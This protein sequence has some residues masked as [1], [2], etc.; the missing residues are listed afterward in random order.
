MVHTSG[1]TGV[2]ASTTPTH[3]GSDLAGNFSNGVFSFGPDR[4]TPD[5]S[6][7]SAA[8]RTADRLGRV[9]HDL[10][11]DAATDEVDAAVAESNGEVVSLN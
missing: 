4:T 8:H 10:G 11:G 6:A 7:F 5:A 3:G 2:H 1:G 9:H